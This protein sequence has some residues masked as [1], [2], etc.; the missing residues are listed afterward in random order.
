MT[1]SFSIEGDS[2]EN[3]IPRYPERLRGFI[4]RV[5]GRWYPGYSGVLG[6]LLA[7]VG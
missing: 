5:L 7:E 6:N 1:W 3:P 4:V 2:L